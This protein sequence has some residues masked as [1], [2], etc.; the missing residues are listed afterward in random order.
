MVENIVVVDAAEILDPAE[1][2]VRWLGSS[3]TVQMVSSGDSNM[4]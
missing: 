3:L 2:G 1:P 4:T